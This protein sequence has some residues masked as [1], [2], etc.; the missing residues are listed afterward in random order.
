LDK[1]ALPEARPESSHAAGDRLDRLDSLTVDPSALSG[2][3]FA[4]RTSW[5]SALRSSSR[6]WVAAAIAVGVL[7]L[8]WQFR[9]PVS[10]QVAN[11]V[12]PQSAQVAPSPATH[13]ATASP[14]VLKQQLVDE[15]RASG[16]EAIGYDRLGLSG[17]DARLPKPL[18]DA[19]RAILA[20]YG[21]PVPPDGVMRVEIAA[22]E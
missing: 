5:I 16:V 15:L 19:T 2:D 9:T 3:P 20:K 21:I 10:R 12:A 14:S 7:A 1:P 4:A 6:A 8:G 11:Q 18:P 22:L 13:L 17:V